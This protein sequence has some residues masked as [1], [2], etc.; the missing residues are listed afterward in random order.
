MIAAEE[1]NSLGCSGHRAIQVHTEPIVRKKIAEFAFKTSSIKLRILPGA[2]KRATRSKEIL[3][4]VYS[5]SSDNPIPATWNADATGLRIKEESNYRSAPRR[6]FLE[7]DGAIIESMREHL[8]EVE[9]EYAVRSKPSL[10]AE[11]SAASA[12]HQV[13]RK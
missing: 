10:R 8:A 1:W 2:A 11:C 9:S 3:K 7:E 13:L 5:E 12:V 6:I 4:R